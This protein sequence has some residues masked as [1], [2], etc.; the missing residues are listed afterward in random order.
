MAQAGSPPRESASAALVLGALGIVYGD[1]GTSPLY[2][3]RESFEGAGHELAVTPENVLG[4][5]SLVVW[6]LVVVISVKY[7]LFVM[8]AD[9]DGEGGILALTSLLRPGSGPR[10]RRRALVLLGL[11]GT[12]LFYGDGMITPAI[13]VLSAVEGT[14]VAAPQLAQYAVPIAIVILVALYAV[15][16][17]ATSTV[18]RAFGPVIVVWFA[19]LGGLG[20]VAAAYGVAVTMTMV[21]TTLVYFSPPRQGFRARKE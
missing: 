7:L 21:I 19:V 1:L 15:Q 9:N 18:G 13:S 3:L 10:R 20:L 8:R 17:R 16:H 6:S 11:F 5:L 2:A 4:I 12:A 14:K